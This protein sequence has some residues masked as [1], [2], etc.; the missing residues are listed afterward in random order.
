[1]A[2][3]ITRVPIHPLQLFH[4]RH[5]R[6]NLTVRDAGGSIVDLTGS[7]VEFAMA[8]KAGGNVVLSVA[9]TLTDPTNGKAQVNIIDTDLDPLPNLD[10]EFFFEVVVTDAVGRES[11]IVRGPVE[12][13]ASIVQT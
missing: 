4:G 2:N 3:V 5:K 1:M 12:F 6:L 7:T 13:N 8:R 11:P 10:G 9:G